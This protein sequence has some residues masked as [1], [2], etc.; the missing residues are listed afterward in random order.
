MFIGGLWV[1]IYGF[2][3]G[4]GW[5]YGEKVFLPDLILPVFQLKFGWAGSLIFTFIILAGL[6]ALVTYIEKKA[7]KTPS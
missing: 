3:V 7:V 2:Q 6:Y 1:P 5:L 4:Q